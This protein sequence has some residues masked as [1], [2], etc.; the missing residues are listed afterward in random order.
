MKTT[1]KIPE[2]VWPASAM[3]LIAFAAIGFFAKAHWVAIML[4]VASFPLL[5]RA[6]KIALVKRSP[7]RPRWGIALLF[8]FGAAVLGYQAVPEATNVPE[9]SIQATGEKNLGSKGSEVWVLGVGTPAGFKVADFHGVDWESRGASLVSYQN[10]PNSVRWKGGWKSGSVLRLSR[11]AYSG[12]AHVT[13][14]AQSQTVDL[15]ASQEAFLDLPLPD[16]EIA[17]V[18]HVAQGAMA[19]MIGAWALWLGLSA[20]RPRTFEARLLFVAVGAALFAFFAIRPLSVVGPVEIVAFGQGEP[21]AKLMVDAGHGF[22]ERLAFSF[23]GL[24]ERAHTTFPLPEG[25]SLS[26]RLS[27]PALRVFHEGGRAVGSPVSQLLSLPEGSGQILAEFPSDAMPFVDWDGAQSGRLAAPEVVLASGEA[28]QRLFLLAQ[29]TREGVLLAWSRNHVVLPAWEVPTY[30]IKRVALEPDSSG[31]VFRVDS[32]TGGF[33][34]LEPSVQ[35]ST[36]IYDLK[37]L[38][39][40]ESRAQL[41]RKIV[42]SLLVGGLVLLLLPARAVVRSFMRLWR[43]GGRLG[44]LAVVGLSTGLPALAVLLAW[45]GILGWDAFSPFLQYSAG[46]LTLWYGI[47]YPLIVPA[48]LLLFGPVAV[49]ILQ[50][51]IVMVLLSWAGLYALE[52]GVRIAWVLGLLMGGLLVTALPVVMLTHLR[53][54]MNA[55]GLAA[56]AVL[57]FAWLQRLRDARASQPWL[58]GAIWALGGFL[59]LMRI[60]NLAFLMAFL[61]MAWLFSRLYARHVAKLWLIVGVMG[62][63]WLS[64]NSVFEHLLVPDKLGSQAEQR[65]YQVTAYINPVFGAYAAGVQGVSEQRDLEAVLEP[66][67]DVNAAKAAWTPFD[68]IYWHQHLKGTPSPEALAALRQQYWRVVQEDFPLFMR[69]RVA[70]FLGMLGHAKEGQDLVPWIQERRINSS[71]LLV[72]HFMSPDPHWQRLIAMADFPYDR[73]PLERQVNLLFDHWNRLMTHVPQLLLVGLCA[74]GIRRAPAAGLLAWAELGRVAVFLFFA[75]AAV[76]LYLGEL[77]FLGLILPMLALAERKRS[78]QA[79]TSRVLEGGAR[80]EAGRAAV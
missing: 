59:T 32:E 6:L 57:A 55:V 54:A 31:S 48:V 76:F 7:S 64:I 34:A 36:R 12:I 78:V 24:G 45:P 25:A 1:W 40:P 49:T 52:N 77:Q 41:M 46:G 11:H 27:Q 65:L 4:L 30:T 14:G 15:F 10:Q 42:A 60:D 39:R 56:F 18:T 35:A 58:M 67:L 75:P 72:D 80:E 50:T 26:L 51:L 47:G 22:S 68:V 70:T 37:P 38:A 79:E 13:I 2:S 21:P 23:N 74:L 63:S 20:P 19:L 69:M 44:A 8:A 29:R 53:D 33:A 3:A 28:S 66:I 16:P 9:L 5:L 17:Y 62:L 61:A 71:L 43:A 73:H